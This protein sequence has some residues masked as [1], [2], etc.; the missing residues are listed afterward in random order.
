MNFGSFSQHQRN[1]LEEGVGTC[2]RTQAARVDHPGGVGG[3][4][5]SRRLYQFIQIEAAVAG[6]DQASFFGP[7]TPVEGQFRVAAGITDQRVGAQKG[8]AGQYGHT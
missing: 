1:G 7:E 5:T 8:S 6:H 2:V 4:Q 3:L